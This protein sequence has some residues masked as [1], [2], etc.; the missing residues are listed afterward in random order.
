MGASWSQSSLA[1]MP[2]RARAELRL[3]R[4]AIAAVLSVSCDRAQHSAGERLVA[5]RVWLS[6]GSPGAARSS[7]ASSSQ[8]VARVGDQVIAAQTVARI[9][10]ARELT[11]EQALE[12]AIRDALLARSAR[13]DERQFSRFRAIALARAQVEQIAR[14]SRDRAPSEEEVRE[15]TALHWLDADRPAMR[16]TTHVVVATNDDTNRER[17]EA[18]A[19]SLAQ[20]TSSV[21]TA[22]SFREA[23][24][25]VIDAR[26]G[27]D[28]SLDVR[29]EDLAPVAADGRA[30]DPQAPP[31]AGIEVPTFDPAFVRAV[32]DLDAVGSLSPVVES[33]YGYHVILLS[34]LIE[35][36]RL[37]FEQRRE[38]FAEE[39]FTNRARAEH[40]ALLGRLAAE[41]RPE[42]SANADALTELVQPEG[43]NLR[44]PRLN[45]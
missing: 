31:P 29:V 26:R 11:A 8:T 44:G 15:L 5:D 38:L 4:I 9:A 36:K 41:I 22:Q 25:R 1:P 2:A 32:F 21:G 28:E 7:E 34:E 17:A 12:L 40:D 43:A 37:G 20:A 45:N 14:A 19:H 24:T 33:P 13:V 18:F 39:I 16:R 35:E 10:A 3:A 27:T 6:R 23:A 42:V 30:A